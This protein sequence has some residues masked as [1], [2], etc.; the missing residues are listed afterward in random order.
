MPND[1][2]EAIDWNSMTSFHAKGGKGQQYGGRGQGRGGGFG[3]GR[4][5]HKP[6]GKGR[7]KGGKGGKGGGGKG[8]KGAAA[9]EAP[10]RAVQCK[11]KPTSPLA[12][13]SNPNLALSKQSAQ[14]KLWP[15]GR[16]ARRHGVRC[17]R[18]LSQPSACY[19][20]FGRLHPITP[21]SPRLRPSGSCGRQDGLHAY[22]AYL[23]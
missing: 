16:A 5:I 2:F 18:R 21:R 13:N 15:P 6:H 19:T 7:G 4:G 8:G 20:A 9:A 1:R 17:G 3:Q 14:M 12:E 10:A 22:R 23:A 11:P